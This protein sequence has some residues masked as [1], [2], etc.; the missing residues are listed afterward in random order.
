MKHLKNNLVVTG[1][2]QERLAYSLQEAAQAMGVSVPTM[3]EWVE[4]TGFPAF[5]AGR[6]YVIPVAALEAWLVDQAAKGAHLVG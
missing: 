3:R 6:R 2:N 4:L 1:G 5:R